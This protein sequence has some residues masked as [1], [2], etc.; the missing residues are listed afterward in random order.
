MATTHDEDGFHRTMHASIM[1]LDEE[2]YR[3]GT[4]PPS[5]TPSP[6]PYKRQRAEKRLAI[7]KRVLR[8][9]DLE[10]QDDFDTED[11]NDEI[12]EV[13]GDFI[14]DEPNHELHY[15]LPFRDEDQETVRKDAEFLR[16]TA[17]LYAEHTL[18]ERERERREVEQLVD[19]DISQFPPTINPP[20]YTFY[21]SSH[22]EHRLVDFMGTLDGIALVGTPGPSS[23]VVF[24]EIETSKLMAVANAAKKWMWS[25]RVRFR[26]PQEISPFEISPLLNFPQSTAFNPADLRYNCFGRLKSTAMHGLYHNDLVFVDVA[27]YDRLW[28][29]PRVHLASPALPNQPP[30]APFG[31]PRPPASANPPNQ[32]RPPRRLLDVVAL[33]RDLPEDQL[34]FN[35]R[36]TRCQWGSRLF[37]PTSGLEILPLALKHDVVRVHPREDEVDLFMASNCE[38]IHA[39][40]TG[41]S[42]A[43]QEGDRVL[44]VD[45]QLCID[46]DGGKIVA[47]FE[48]REGSNRVRMAVV[49]RPEWIVAELE[50]RYIVR[51][52]SSLRLH[53]LSW[54][55]AVN[56]GDRV[57]VVAGSGFRGYSGRIFDLPTPTSIR[58]ESLEPETLEVEVALRHVRLDFRRGDV[59]R[60][61]RGDHKDKIGLVV[62]LCLG[63]DMDVYVCDSARIN[64]CLRPSFMTAGTKF[65]WHPQRLRN[66]LALSSDSPRDGLVVILHK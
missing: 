54:R 53:I 29:V 48:R 11:N 52:V 30:S 3:P 64:K 10:A 25:H 21:V 19:E 47:I 26:G 6:P 57:I 14:D 32:P 55:R 36:C 46:G 39:T 66:V 22:W 20:L 60:V 23:C 7:P 15:D 2:H 58:F 31:Q 43:L 4:P 40:F 51:P 13:T 33:K 17:A 44:V 50:P 63:G 65:S 28:V 35:D 49:S 1:E 9:L 42:C 27:D 5:R 62:A 12:Q 38:E 18:E 61:V 37:S 56:I 8:L 59:V 34:V 45:Q 41:P 16:E 24:F